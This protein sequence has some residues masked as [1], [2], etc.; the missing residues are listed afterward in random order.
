MRPQ[1]GILGVR[2]PLPECDRILFSSMSLLFL[3]H[4]I[5]S[6]DVCSW[7]EDFRCCRSAV[8]R[9][10]CDLLCSQP[11]HLPHHPN[12]TTQPNAWNKANKRIY[13]HLIIMFV[14]ISDLVTFPSSI[15]WGY[16]ISPSHGQDIKQPQPIASQSVKTNKKL[17]LHQ[18]HRW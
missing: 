11:A 15:T 14:V 1:G 8:T 9:E 16:H 2:H 10:I 17:I 6:L 5:N 4:S 7:D 13:V 12:T 18:P 3:W